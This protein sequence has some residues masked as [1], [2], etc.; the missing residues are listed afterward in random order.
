MKKVTQ[1]L[2]VILLIVMGIQVEASPADKGSVLKSFFTEKG[3]SVISNWAH[4]LSK[5]YAAKTTISV[6]SSSVAITL[7][8]SK[9]NINYSCKYSININSSN[10]LSSLTI[11][12]E[13]YPKYP[14][15]Y[16]CEKV[17]KLQSDMK[18]YKGNNEVVKIVEG[19]LHKSVAAFSCK[20]YCLL[21]LNYYWK[22]NGYR[23]KYLSS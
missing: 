7:F 9:S 13:G 18:I 22:V 20:D 23:A 17:K 12:S 16:S 11:I 6:S 21:G 1:S 3:A 15:F 4:P 14:C 19:I 2:L 8:Y 5:F 10:Y